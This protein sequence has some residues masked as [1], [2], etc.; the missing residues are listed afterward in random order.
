MN[1]EDL[2]EFLDLKFTALSGKLEAR[3]DI[4]AARMDEAIRHQKEMNSQ[5]AKNVKAI[6]DTQ[7][8]VTKLK[9]SATEEEHFRGTLKKITRKWYLLLSGATVGWYGLYEL[10]NKFPTVKEVIDFIKFWT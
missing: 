10:H 6:N 8:A 2:K 9:E 4:L 5:V 7:E 1:N 3:D